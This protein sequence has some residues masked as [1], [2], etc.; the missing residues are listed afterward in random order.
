MN[1][2]VRDLS[3]IVV[4]LILLFYIGIKD[5]NL[6]FYL[7]V[8]LAFVYFVLT[9]DRISYTVS[10][11][12]VEYH[13]QKI[14][15]NIFQV[16]AYNNDE[17]IPEKFKKVTDILKK[18]NPEYNYYIYNNSQ[19]E[20]FVKEHFPEYYES[21]SSINKEY[22]VAKTDFFRYMVVYH[23]GGVYIDIKSGFKVPLREIIKTGDEFITTAFAGKSWPLFDNYI[24]FCI[25]SRKRHPVLKEILDEINY[26]LKNYDYNRDG[27]GLK[28]VHSITG[29]LMFQ[30]V[31]NNREVLKD[32]TDITHYSNLID[33]KLIYSYFDENHLDSLSC[34]LFSYTAGNFGN[35]KHRVGKSYKELTGPIVSLEE[36]KDNLEN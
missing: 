33:N 31:L 25:I 15:K 28:G 2:L 36:H 13:E 9:K 21:Y 4:V 11:K 1:N 14:E 24:Q 32:K 35:C 3:L 10:D 27:Y 20:S 7:I 34:V 30:K 17:E 8:V 12:Q 6:I 22:N 5:P 16:Y 29:P 23:Y 26:R 19:M 18:Q